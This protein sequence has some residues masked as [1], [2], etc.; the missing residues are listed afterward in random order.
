MS[1]GPRLAL[2]VSLCAACSS[3]PSAPDPTLP[4]L[5]ISNVS[6][7][8]ATVSLAGQGSI[9]YC[10]TLRNDGAGKTT[11]SQFDI[12]AYLSTDQTLS[13]DDYQWTRFYRA[14]NYTL[15]AG[16]A[17]EQCGSHTLNNPLPAVGAYY[18]IVV[19]DAFPGQPPNNYPGVVEANETNNWR[20]SATRV[21]IIP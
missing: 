18:L 9:V 2:L 14:A 7:T 13:G 6:V 12:A 8:A 16:F 15:T 21:T 1:K 3:S 4:D 17:S 10:Y 19:A 20:A 11:E 5:V